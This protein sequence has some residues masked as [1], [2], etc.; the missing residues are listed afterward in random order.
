MNPNGIQNINP[1]NPLTTTNTNTK[2][3]FPQ[4]IEN[5]IAPTFDLTGYSLKTLKWTF[6]QLFNGLSNALVVPYHIQFRLTENP[7]KY[8]AYTDPNQR[9]TFCK[10]FDLNEKK[11]EKLRQLCKK[12]G[13]SVVHA[14]STAVLLTTSLLL[15]SQF[16]IDNDD[17]DNNNDTSSNSRKY[18]VST[19]IYS[20]N[21][22]MK[23]LVIYIYNKNIV[24]VIFISI[25]I[26]ISI[27]ISKNLRLKIRSYDYC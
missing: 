8:I 27:L 15:Q 11:T 23:F 16:V 22:C 3:K 4:S 7:I 12:Q 24:I 5:V 6:F 14:L 26:H 1:I 19:V 18:E 13:V 9:N 17:A 10:Y 21:I 2:Y 25:L 20:N